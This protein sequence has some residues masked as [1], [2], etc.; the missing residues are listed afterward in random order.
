[1]APIEGKVERAAPDEEGCLGIRMTTGAGK[2]SVAFLEKGG[3]LCFWY[4]V[5]LVAEIR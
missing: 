4:R 5:S 2:L 1:V 3:S